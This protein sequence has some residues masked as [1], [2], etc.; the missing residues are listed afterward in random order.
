MRS[1]REGKKGGRGK[2]GIQPVEPVVRVMSPQQWL[3]QLMPGSLTPPT[4]FCGFALSLSLSPRSARTTQHNECQ[5]LVLGHTSGQGQQQQQG[6]EPR[7]D[8]RLREG[9]SERLSHCHRLIKF[10]AVAIE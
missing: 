10:V 3:K 7:L 8:F 2:E 4:Q 5:A 1:K 6:R 9:E